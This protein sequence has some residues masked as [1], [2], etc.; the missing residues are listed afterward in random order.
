MS[1]PAR[2]WGVVLAAA[3]VLL[4]M[5]VPARASGF[6]LPLHEIAGAAGGDVRLA[7]P[8]ADPRVEQTT[9]VPRPPVQVQTQRSG[10]GSLSV[11][12]TAGQGSLTLIRFGDAPSARLD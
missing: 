7:V 6:E 4:A 8:P 9:C 1:G 5:L 11:T 2:R 10:E 3:M 12:I